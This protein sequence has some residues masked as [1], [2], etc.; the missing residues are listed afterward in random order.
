[1]GCRMESEKSSS[2]SG[3]SSNCP[4]PEALPY[5][6]VFFRAENKQITKLR[7]YSANCALDF[8]NLPLYWL[9]DVKPEQSVEILTKMALADNGDDVYR[10][11]DPARSA[12]MA[13]AMH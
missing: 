12:I 13:I 6:F 11:K 8:A 4:Q 1:M 3:T 7:V 10:K 9:E 5:A 2:F